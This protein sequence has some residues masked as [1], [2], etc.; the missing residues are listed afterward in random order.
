MSHKMTKETKTY[1]GTKLYRIE[2][3]SGLKGGW[4][5]FEDNL[6]QGARLDARSMLMGV[7]QVESDCI[8]ECDSI[9]I[10]S[11]IRKGSSVNNCKIVKSK[12]WESHL[13]H[14]TIKNHSDLM[15]T[16]LLHSEVRSSELYNV[17]AHD[18]IFDS[19]ESINCSVYNALILDQLDAIS[20][21]N[22]NFGV[23]YLRRTDTLAVG[24]QCFSVDQWLKII[25]SEDDLH[26]LDSA[27]DH[28][29]MISIIPR[30]VEVL[31]CLRQ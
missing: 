20:I 3:N 2:Y 28:S 23:T 12:V 16:S 25:E 18:S 31:R 11:M 13:L 30:I 19:V 14:S 7:T 27:H 24:C 5:E 6:K 1:D 21:C 22:F 15:N 17:E 29:I 4:V 26:E 10:D 9:I 8:V